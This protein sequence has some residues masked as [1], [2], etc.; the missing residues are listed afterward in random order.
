MEKNRELWPDQRL[1]EIIVAWVN[2]HGGDPKKAFP[3]YPKRGR[4]GPRIRKVRLRKKQQIELMAKVSTGFADLGNNHHIA[5]YR[6][7]DGKVK[8]EVV[9]LM[10]A[11]RRLARHEPVVRRDCGDGAQF[12]MSLSL[13]DSL[14]LT[15][16]GETSVRVVSSVWG[17]AKS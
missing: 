11:S 10:E 8:H 17:T 9:S 2:K 16:N 4:N 5:I 3:P 13:G 1:R 12:L 7:P 6:L 15:R 14:R